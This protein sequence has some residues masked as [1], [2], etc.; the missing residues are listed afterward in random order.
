MESLEH[1]HV[2]RPR[3]ERLLGRGLGWVEGEAE[4]KRQ[5]KLTSPAVSSVAHATQEKPTHAEI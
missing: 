5:R 1:S 4:H 2:V 3:I